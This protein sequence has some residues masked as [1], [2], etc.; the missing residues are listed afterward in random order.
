MDVD[1]IMTDEE[2]EKALDDLAQY[3]DN[4]IKRSLAQLMNEHQIITWEE[5]EQILAD[6][7]DEPI[8]CSLPQQTRPTEPENDTNPDQAMQR[9]LKNDPNLSTVNLNN[10]KRIPIPQLK[11]VLT[12]MRENEYIEK[13]S[14]ANMGLYDNDVEPLIDILEANE[15]LR[16][17]NLETNYLSGEFFAK[18]FQAALKNQTLE[19][20]KAVNQGV[21]FSTT[22]ERD[23]IKAIFQNRGLLKVSFNFRLPEG[24]HK[25]EQATMRNQ[26]IRR[27]LRRQAAEEAR[28][29]EER[30]RVKEEPKPE[31]PKPKKEP[32]IIKTAPS[33]LKTAGAREIPKPVEPPKVEAPK[34]EVPKA[35]TKP[36]TNFPSWRRPKAPEEQKP[37]TSDENKRSPFKASND[38]PVVAELPKKK[39]LVK[40]SS[41]SE[42]VDDVDNA[43]PKIKKKKKPTAMA[44][45]ILADPVPESNGVTSKLNGIKK[46]EKS[47]ELPPRPKSALTETPSLSHTSDSEPTNRLTVPKDKNLTT[48]TSATSESDAPNASPKPKK[49]IIRRKKKVVTDGEPKLN[50]TDSKTEKKIEHSEVDKVDDLKSSKTLEEPKAEN[51]EK[52]DKLD[53]TDDSKVKEAKPPSDLLTVEIDDIEEKQSSQSTPKEA[54]SD[55]PKEEPKTEDGVIKPKKKIIKRK[56]KVVTDGEP[57]LNGIDTKLEGSKAEDTKTEDLKSA[58]TAVKPSKVEEEPRKVFSRSRLYG[59]AYK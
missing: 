14:L 13:L 57:K 26:E 35:E 44:P 21:S 48:T 30:K 40:K 4:D 22:S 51:T 45:M 42:T 25:V 23:I 16:V 58:S 47:T 18:L 1:T 15:S 2:L 32:V 43:T 10:M 8:K 54:L 17:L 56:K 27:I 28:L 11:R 19:E 31:P 52:V 3:A 39:T 41:S 53:K 7:G 33:I 59:G 6:T 49:K 34:A 24:R 50:G 37:Q 29:E 38:K 9:L 36:E 55:T 46:E 5:A 20:V 12:A